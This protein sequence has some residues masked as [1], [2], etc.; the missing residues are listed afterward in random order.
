MVVHYDDMELE[1]NARR[2]N[3][4]DVVGVFVC[5]YFDLG[6]SVINKLFLKTGVINNALCCQS[7]KSDKSDTWRFQKD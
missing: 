3:N 7:D 5:P 4:Y 6:L 1:C 2:P